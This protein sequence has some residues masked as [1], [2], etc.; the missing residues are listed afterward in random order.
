MPVIRLRRTAPRAA[1]I[2][3]PA[4]GY[5]RFKPTSRRTIPGDPD[6]TVLPIPFTEDLVDGAAEVTL[7]PTGPGWAWAILESIDGV[8]DERFYVLVPDVPGPLDDG[9]LIR[10][11]P[12]TLDPLAAPAPEWWAAVDAI[13]P[14]PGA[15]YI[16]TDDDGAPYFA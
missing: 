4:T 5:F 9:E 2:D 12:A 10:V 1:G 13:T 6:V 7:A 3:A 11:D 16:L 15:A 8:P 14:P